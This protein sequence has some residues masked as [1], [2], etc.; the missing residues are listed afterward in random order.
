MIAYLGPKELSVI[1]EQVLPFH[2]W[3]PSKP[4]DSIVFYNLQVQILNF[5]DKNEHYVANDHKNCQY[6]DEPGVEPDIRRSLRLINEEEQVEA[7]DRQDSLI[8]DS[9]SVDDV[10]FIGLDTEEHK[11]H[12]NDNKSFNVVS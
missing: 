4:L 11:D 6:D 2:L 8:N 9:E 3:D 5:D 10:V 7:D 1:E 12:L